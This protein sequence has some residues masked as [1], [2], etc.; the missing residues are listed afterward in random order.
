VH[1]VAHDSSARRDDPGLEFFGLGVK[2]HN[3][4]RLC[5]RFPVPNDVSRSGNAVGL[6]P[7]AARRGSLDDLAGLGVEAAQVAAR[8][9]EIRKHAV[10]KENRVDAQS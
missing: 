10:S 3:Y 1:H 8:I 4:V 6:G 2:A 9:V 7:R 5:V